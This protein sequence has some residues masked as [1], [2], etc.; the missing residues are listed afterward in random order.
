MD[1]QG[2]N[3]PTGRLRMPILKLASSVEGWQGSLT[4]TCL[5]RHEFFS[6]TL[7]WLESCFGWAACFGESPQALGVQRRW[8]WAADCVRENGMMQSWRIDN[9]GHCHTFKHRSEISVL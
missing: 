3:L 6:W 2:G 9:A 4:L 7:K 5:G 1:K 8:E